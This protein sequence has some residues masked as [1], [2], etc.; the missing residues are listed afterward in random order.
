MQQRILFLY[1]SG[2]AGLI[3]VSN[4]K[5]QEVLSSL[6][7]V[8]I[9]RYDLF[10]EGLGWPIGPLGVKWWNEAQ[11]KGDIK[12][13]ERL[14]RNQPNCDRLFWPF[15]FVRMVKLLF[16]F[17]PDRV[18]NTSPICITSAIRAIRFYNW[19]TKRSV[20]LELVLVDLPTD[21]CTHFF[22]PL[23]RISPKDQTCLKVI[24][25]PPFVK[26][27]ETESSF[28]EKH[29]SLPLSAIEVVP[30]TVREPFLHFAAGAKLPTPFRF[31]AAFQSDE[32]VELLKK[33]LSLAPIRYAIGNREVEFTLDPGERVI[34]LLL[35][36]QPSE[37][38]TVNYVRRLI[39]TAREGGI[40]ATTHLFVLAGPH[41]PGKTS[42]YR[43]IAEEVAKAHP[44]PLHVSVVP[45][46]YQS[47]EVIASLF[48]R[49]DATV[50][51]SG[52]STM[53]E[54]IAVSRGA[55]WIHTEAKAGENLLEGIPKWEAGNA[56]YMEAVRGAKIVTPESFAPLAKSLMQLRREK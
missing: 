23:K 38:G 28:W 54:L 51:R 33:A 48:V 32:E 18:I 9:K 22:D 16:Q 13:L 6:P 7:D 52:G 25:P 27:G 34:T 40:Q 29:T 15:V 8:V 53:M 10:E 36:S 31:K 42:L 5:Q 49:S 41:F 44:Y 30:Y 19:A 1:S 17:R 47:E 50:T 20:Y 11:K 37:R 43:Q 14:I 45:L 24:S 4:A 46:S 21:R 2:G 39:E 55:V 3:Q 56:L 35:G 26:E 12:R